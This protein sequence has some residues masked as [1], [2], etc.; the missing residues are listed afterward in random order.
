MQLKEQANAVPAKGL[1]VSSNPVFDTLTTSSPIAVRSRLSEASQST[2]RAFVLST[3]TFPSFDVHFLRK[4]RLYTKLKYSRCPQYDIVSGGFAA[5]LAGFIGF[6]I[7]EKFGIELVDS[8]DFY[9]GFMYV[10]FA[11]FSLK[12]LIYVYTRDDSSYTPLSLKY[13]VAFIHDLLVLLLEFIVKSI[14]RVLV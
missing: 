2:R 3:T 12:P 14:N 6:L 5:V 11:A 8:G 10:V 1:Y 4:E 9:I 7:S 13:S